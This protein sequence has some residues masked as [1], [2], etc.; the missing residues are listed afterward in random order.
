MFGWYG[1]KQAPEEQEEAAFTLTLPAV[2]AGT[3]LLGPSLRISG[4]ITG[5]GNVQLCGRHEG[6]IDLQGD[7]TIQESAVVSGWIAARSISVGGSVEGELRARQML[8]VQRTAR[9][10]GTIA[11]PRVMVAEGALVEG[12]VEMDGS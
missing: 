10:N 8:A 4:K 11:T 5:E 3:S 12:K 7:L 1:K 2:D 6:R 9:V